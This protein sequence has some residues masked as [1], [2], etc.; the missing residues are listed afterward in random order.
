MEIIPE[1]I[2]H[3]GVDVATCD[4]K[5]L[6]RRLAR[7]KSTLQV[8]DGG[9][10]REDRSYSQVHIETHFTEEELDK[11]LYEVNHG[12]DYVGVFDRNEICRES[13]IGE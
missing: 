8:T 10:Y 11:W 2:H 9:E 3:L 12:A 6:M 7:L 1:K 4:K 13:N 5:K